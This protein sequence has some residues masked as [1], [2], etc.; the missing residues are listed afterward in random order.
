MVFTAILAVLILIAIFACQEPGSNI[1]RNTVADPK[2]QIPQSS[3]PQTI[4][5]DAKLISLFF[6]DGWQNQYNVALPV[7]LQHSFRATFGIITDYIGTGEGTWEYMGDKE[8]GNLAEC[9]MDVACHTKTHPHL[10]ELTDKQ[11]YEEIIDSKKDLEKLGPEVRTFVYPYCEWDD[12]LVMYVKKA[13]FICARSCAWGEK[14]YD[15]NVTDENA[16]YHVHSYSIVKHD[17]EQFKAITNQASR[18]NVVCLCYHFISDIGP[19]ET[20]TPV[21]NFLT[22]MWYLKKSGFTVVLLPDL[23]K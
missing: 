18:H 14:P 12:R 21:D 1:S 6:D 8:I 11:L 2:P 16:R 5:S 13:G 17:F 10:T 7:L 20:S 3:Q 23:M 4:P 9:G 15:L 22:Q 19:E